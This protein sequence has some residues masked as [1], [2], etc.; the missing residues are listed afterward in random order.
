MTIK[1]IVNSGKPMQV[2]FYDGEDMSSG[3][4]V[5][6]K[7]ICGCCGALFEVDEIVKNAREDGV[8]HPILMYSYWVDLSD[9]IRGD[10]DNN[11]YLLHGTIALEVEDM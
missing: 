4:M 8:T 7:I 2:L 3:I 6:D 10:N 9:E 1:E 11:D 5:G